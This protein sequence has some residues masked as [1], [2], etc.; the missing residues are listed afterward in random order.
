VA[1]ELLDYHYA[2]EKVR[3]MAVKAIE[4][5]L[6]N[7]EL[8]NFLL[9]LVQVSLLVTYLCSPCSLYRISVCLVCAMQKYQE[10]IIYLYMYHFHTSDQRKVSAYHV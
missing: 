7:D 6:S 5:L 1:L 3:T 2:D 8:H 9:Q 10:F 4:R